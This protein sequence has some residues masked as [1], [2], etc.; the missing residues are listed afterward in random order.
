MGF[1][2]FEKIISWLV[3]LYYRRYNC[4]KLDIRFFNFEI[5][6]C[7]YS[8]RYDDMKVLCGLCIFFF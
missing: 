6:V 5:I 8:D 3:E 4:L 1:F 7:I 2:F